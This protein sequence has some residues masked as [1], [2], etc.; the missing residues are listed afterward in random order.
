MEKVKRTLYV[1]AAKTKG[2]TTKGDTTGITE[3]RGVIETEVF[4]SKVFSKGHNNCGEFNAI[5]DGYKKLQ[6]DINFFDIIYSDSVT[7]ISWVTNQKI[8]CS[9]RNEFDKEFL[10]IVE[11]NEEWM[12]ENKR[13]LQKNINKL[14]FWDKKKEGRETPADFGNK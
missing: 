4:R 10:K 1:D 7:A 8:N 11:S 14:K 5:I 13:F 3:W 6:E 9:I 12:Q 2:G